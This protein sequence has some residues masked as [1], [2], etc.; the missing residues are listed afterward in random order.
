MLLYSMFNKP[1][2]ILGKVFP[3]SKDDYDHIHQFSQKVSQLLESGLL[4]PMK[5]KLWEGGLGKVAEALK[6]LEEGKVNA[7]KLVIET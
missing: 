1:F 4:K 5:V 2:E 6:Y 3:A 7:E